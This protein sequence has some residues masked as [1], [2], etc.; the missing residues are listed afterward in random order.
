MSYL[1]TSGKRV[2]RRGDPSL[3]SFRCSVSW[4]PARKTVSEKLG[5]LSKDDGD[6]AE[7]NA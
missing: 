1:V 2:A 5:S 4:G 7:D 6:D 3:A